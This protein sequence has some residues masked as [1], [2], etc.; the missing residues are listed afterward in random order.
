MENHFKDAL[1]EIAV[2][3]PPE[4]VYEDPAQ[5]SSQSYE[6]DKEYAKMDLNCFRLIFSFSSNV[7][8]FEAMVVVPQIWTEIY[9]SDGFPPRPPK[10]PPPWSKTISFSIKK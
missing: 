4:H 5:E 10:K 7:G 1:P 2:E 9:F 3:C 6:K 8:V